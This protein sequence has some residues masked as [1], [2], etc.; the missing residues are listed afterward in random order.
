MPYDLY[1]DAAHGVLKTLIE[2]FPSVAP[3]L[4][5]ASFEDNSDEIPGSAFAWPDRR[6][7]PVHTPE[8]A[9]LSHMYLSKEASAPE[10]VR[11]AVKEA[12]LAYGVSEDAITPVTVKVA[13]DPDDF[14]FEDHTYPVRGAV[15]VKYAEQRLLEQARNMALPQRVETFHK[16]AQA[17]KRHSVNLTPASQAWGM[18]GLSNREKVAEALTARGTLAK[19]ASE[20]QGYTDIAAALRDDPKALREF[21][22]QVKLAKL[23]IGMDARAGLSALYDSKIPDPFHTVFNTAVK[24]GAQMIDLGGATFDLMS[25]ASLPSTF[26]SDALGPEIVGQIAPGGQVNPD[27]LAMILPTLPADMKQ[28]LIVSLSSAGVKPSPV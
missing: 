19:T 3:L 23:L 24:L 5:T 6:M 10:R 22:S 27:Q 21:N 2:Q 18:A 14:L 4:K 7:Y 26:Y 8:H 1:H 11:L 17:A 9:I 15:E 16:L 28:S 13:E 12:L 20:K 25:L